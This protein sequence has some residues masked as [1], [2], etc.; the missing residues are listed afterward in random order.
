LKILAI[1]TWSIFQT[2]LSWQSV[3]SNVFS[4]NTWMVQWYEVSGHLGGSIWV[5]TINYI[6]YKLIKNR[7]LSLKN[8]GL[9]SLVIIIPIV[10]G[11][12]LQA[13]QQSKI[14][15]QKNY[16]NII[17]AQPN[18][19]PYTEKFDIPFDQQIFS[20]IKLS[21][22]LIDDNTTKLVIWPETAIQEEMN[23]KE[24]ITTE[25]YRIITTWL[26]RHPKVTLLS[27]CNTWRIFDENE[28]HPPTLRKRM[29]VYGYN[30]DGTPIFK[31]LIYE[32]YN[33]SIQLNAKGDY[34]IYHKSRLVPGV[35][36]MPFP[37]FFG[38]LED[39]SIDLGGMSG[40]LG[41]DSTSK[42]FSIDSHLVAAPIICYES[43]FGEYV[44]TYIQKGAS[45]I[46]IMT[47]DGWWNETDGFKQHL[48]YAKL[49]AIETRKWVYRSANTGTS[50]VINPLG[51]ILLERG[52]DI[53]TAMKYNLYPNH[54]MTLYVLSGDVIGKA[55]LYLSI[56]ILI[57]TF[58]LKIF[59]IKLF[60]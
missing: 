27:G 31:E 29:V 12:I 30:P 52:W 47:N 43:V 35:E 16:G 48:S 3:F 45:I 42:V 21:D 25:S 10:I 4:E 23:E 8:I 39:F 37:A 38:F 60:N 28:K 55:M 49:R 14:N 34:S 20:L 57:A 6:L 18:I 44:G 33:S 1:L 50:A 56:L 36:K 46:T 19:D 53:K 40:S 26:N 58:I 11:S 5:L 41:S 15:S 7:Q 17:I 32:S 2:F 13:N 22:S 24:I 54:Q 51:E 9:T 59:K